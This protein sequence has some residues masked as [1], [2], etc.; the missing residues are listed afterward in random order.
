GL[1]SA[2]LFYFGKK[3]KDMSSYEAAI[4]IALL[5]GPNYYHPIRRTGRL[6]KR[7]NFVFEKLKNE[8]LFSHGK[9]SRK[10]SSKKWKR[11]VRELREREK[12][13]SFISL[14]WAALRAKNGQFQDYEK[15]TFIKKAEDLRSQILKRF[16][17][18]KDISIKGI[19]GRPFGK[20]EEDPFYYYSKRERSLNR[21]VDGERHQVG[22]ILKPLI[23]K[24]FLENG[25]RLEDFV[26]LEKVTLNL[27][28]G[29][30]A[31]REAHKR[32]PKKVS[33]GEALVKSFNRPVVRIA[34]EVGFDN[35]E[36]KLRNFVPRLKSPLKEYPSQLLGSVDLSLRE[37][38]E[39]YKKF[40]REDCLYRKSK[41]LPSII[42]HLSNP[43]NSTVRRV[44]GPFLKLMK[45][46]GKTGTSN[47]GQDNWYVFFTGKEL[48][49]LW[50]GLEGKRKGQDLR[51]F[52]STTSFKLFQ[53]FYRERGK[54][55]S[56]LSCF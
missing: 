55:F 22:S 33:L 14:E 47:N 21:S 27:K 13:R 46:F 8:N 30:W 5:K 15:F 39:I 4:L 19:I 28:S 35:I 12:R 52:G 10:W 45:Y 1:F 31:P 49:V 9:M 7:T 56:E 44:V 53:D 24:T 36:K 20:G 37:V 40:I 18:P 23:Y 50:V 34:S 32:L 11:W 2:S 29:F 41:R 6:K 51:L 25:R 17:E 54:S 48:G 43:Q 16:K 26:S 42:E 38:Y 3:P